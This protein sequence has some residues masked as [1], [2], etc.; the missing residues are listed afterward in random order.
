[1]N[2]DASEISVPQ[3]HYNP[4]IQIRDLRRGP[5]FYTQDEALHSSST[6]ND[7]LRRGYMDIVNAGNSDPQRS[8]MELAE[9]Y[10][11]LID[12]IP[13]RWRSEEL[14]RDNVCAKENLVIYLENYGSL[15][16]LIFV[17]T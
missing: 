15:A 14:C 11:K 17:R 12:N 2:S 4:G 7:T 8:R 5:D 1:M 13:E 3:Q 9:M 10:Q 16:V 6:E